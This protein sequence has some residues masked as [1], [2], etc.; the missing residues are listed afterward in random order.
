MSR[1]FRRIPAER[2]SAEL[3]I[4]EALWRD[5]LVGMNQLREWE[6]AAR[7]PDADA[8][9]LKAKIAARKP[10]LEKVRR[11]AFEIL[12]SGVARMKETGVVNATVPRAVL[13]LAQIYVDS[14]E[15]PRRSSCWTIPRSAS[16]R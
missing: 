10:E 5:Y 4:G 13:S 12:E 9:E 14:D 3:R 2:G 7:E 16:C 15:A 1:T 6:K 11:T 8:A